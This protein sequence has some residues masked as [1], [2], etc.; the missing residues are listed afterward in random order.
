MKLIE[1]ERQHYVANAK[2]LGDSTA[3]VHDFENVYAALT[4]CIEI[5]PSEPQKMAVVSMIYL[6]VFCRRQLT[7]GVLTLMRS[8]RADSLLHLR[9]AIETCAFAVRI[10]KHPD[11]A[12]VWANGGASDDAY[13]AYRKAFRP[14]DVF[15]PD[16]DHEQPLSILKER[17]DLCSTLMHG[18][19]FG[20]AGQ[21]ETTPESFRL[22]FFDLPPDHSLFSVLWQ[23]LDTHKE[24][25]HFFGR[26]FDPHTNDQMAAWKVR[27]NAVEAKLA[28]HGQRWTPVILNHTKAF[29]LNP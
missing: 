4:P 7:I 14:R 20:M 25:L 2:A 17:Y 23:M 6:L 10:C 9:R 13:A 26:V 8:Y 21:F 16:P 12:T 22:E 15:P 18:G 27:L 24:M 28:V 1:D 11:L 19:V 5:P 29:P 3:L